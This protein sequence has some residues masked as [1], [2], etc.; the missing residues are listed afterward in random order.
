[1]TLTEKNLESTLQ[2]SMSLPVIVVFAAPES[3]H[4]QTLISQ[5]TNLITKRAGRIQLAVV[6][7]STERGV[8]GAF[9][10]QAVPS[11]VAL[12]QGQPVPL[13]QGLPDSQAIDETLSK[14]LKAGEQYGLNGV[15]DG[16][17]EGAAPEPEIPPLHQEGLVA[18]EAGNLDAA[19][20]A[21][22]AAIKE[23]PGDLEAKTALNQVELLQRVQA[24]N[25]QNSP[26]EAQGLLHAAASSPL[27][28]IDVHLQAADLELSFG[29]AEA[30][31][32]RL[33]DVI[34]ATQGEDRDLVRTRLLALFDIV[35]QHSPS[36]HQARKALTNALF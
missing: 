16:D 20:A 33:I 30:A 7:T 17:P 31:F 5:L 22:T 23:N 32:T 27:T 2:T 25:P 13:F 11:V 21:Y 18:L 35:G 15:L 4:S 6:D 1:M 29:H 12:L 24:I 36:V 19:H 9:G 28:E 34:K 14:L 10:I 26:L 3:E 8:A